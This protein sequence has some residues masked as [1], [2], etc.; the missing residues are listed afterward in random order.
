M[1]IGSGAVIN[2]GSFANLT[3]LK[4]KKFFADQIG[5]ISGRAGINLDIRVI[6]PDIY[7]RLKLAE[8][9]DA[10]SESAST[11]LF[12]DYLTD[13]S[14]AFLC[15]RLDAPGGGV[16]CDVVPARFNSNNDGDAKWSTACLA[17]RRVMQVEIRAF[18]GLKRASAEDVRK[19]IDYLI[20]TIPL[21]IE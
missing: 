19:I 17:R 20:N 9:W 10:R 15:A 6:D 4:V 2:F 11:A 1:K 5:V 3:L 8:V 7:A 16:I 14:V 21:P 12:E 18:R 13:A